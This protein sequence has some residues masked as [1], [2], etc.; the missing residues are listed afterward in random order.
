[1]RPWRTWVTTAFLILTCAAGLADPAAA[2]GK[3]EGEIRYAV[4]ATIAPAWFDPGES[5]VGVLTPFWIS[6]ALHDAVV[7]PMPGKMLTPS[8]AESWTVSDD[9]RVYEF[10]LR[11]GLKF[12]NGDP[13]T[14]EDV[15]FSF[16]RAKATLLLSKVKE[17]VVVDPATVRFVLH[18]PWP[19]FMTF[20]GTF[21]SGAGWVLP[22]RYFEQVGAD[23]FKRHPIGLGPYKFLSNKPGLELVL[24]A[25]E[26]YWR[27]MPSVKRLVFKSIPE[28]T[29]RAAMLLRDEVDVAYLLDASLG[30]E[31]RRNPK[32]KLAF[33][34]GIGTYYLDF[35]DMW[36]PKS[37]WA[38]PKV[39]RAAS[40]A[41]DRKTLSEAETLGASTPTGN[42][43]PPG[44]EYALKIEPDPYDPDQA[45]KLLAEAGFPNGF[46]GGDLHPWPP[47]YS[48][49]E[50]INAYLGA[51]GI[52]TRLRT[53]ERAT[54][55]AE[56]ATKKLKGV[57]MCVNAVYGNASSRLSET[58]PSNGAFAYGGY[59]DIDALY[60]RQATELDPTAR[61]A[62]LHQIQQ[63]L[64]ERTRFAPI[65]EYI[66][67]SG[68]GP[69]VADPALMLINPYPWSAPLED[70][71]MK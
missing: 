12:H 49:G 10:K 9:H 15:R 20:Y 6:F 71:R 25:Y 44:F 34:G 42:V 1:M 17:V 53:M 45:K 50:A 54:F 61:T 33:S 16:L 65:F 2:Q 36:D 41:I 27:K 29:T 35:L 62:T 3:P 31:V 43:V 23:G 5:V 8:L 58:V 4:Y 18:E 52:R 30:E 69:K 46:D 56:L 26:G 14:A 38:N 28:A 21:A 37:P 57:C 51:I 11:Q 47:Y 39:R 64:R 55:Y 40:L 24:E 67:I 22:K 7:K 19:D 63:T 60:A 68:I 13:F 59:P 66:W 70:V 32:F 48:A